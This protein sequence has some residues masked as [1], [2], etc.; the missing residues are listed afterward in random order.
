MR[1]SGWTDCSTV[2]DVIT[3]HANKCC[4]SRKGNVFLDFDRLLNYI[5]PFLSISLVHT[6]DNWIVKAHLLHLR[7]QPTRPPAFVF[8]E[9]GPSLI[10]LLQPIQ[11]QPK[12]VHHEIQI[13]LVHMDVASDRLPHHQFINPHQPRVALAPSLHAQSTDQMRRDAE[14]REMAVLRP[15][16]VVVGNFEAEHIPPTV[17]AAQQISQASQSR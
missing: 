9:L 2:G 12:S 14:N 15:G 3:I 8:L 13:M 11:V 10:V 1:S 4:D 7:R 17:L 5:G 6:V 16:N